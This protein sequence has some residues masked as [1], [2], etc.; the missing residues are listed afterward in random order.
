MPYG[1]RTMMMYRFFLSARE[2]TDT[3]TWTSESYRWVALVCCK[4]QFTFV[5]TRSFNFY[6][7]PAIA[8]RSVHLADV[9]ANVA[10]LQ[11][12][13]AELGCIFYLSRDCITAGEFVCI[14]QA[15]FSSKCIGFGRICIPIGSDRSCRYG[16]SSVGTATPSAWNNVC[17]KS[18]TGSRCAR[19]IC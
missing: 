10:H 14:S 7:R 2:R 6:E 5:P 3:W 8:Y 13:A 18:T 1:C 15:R 12:A 17:A 4:T 11:P 9:C 16:V 19:L